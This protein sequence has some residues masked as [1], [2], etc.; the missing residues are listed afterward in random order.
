[1][2]RLRRFFAAPTPFVGSVVPISAVVSGGRSGRQRRKVDAAL[3]GG[4]NGFRTA[5]R[6]SCDAIGS[7]GVLARDSF[8]GRVT[9]R[10]GVAA[11]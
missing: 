10:S 3:T 11:S 1:M 7:C 5:T 4:Q 9:C 8:V 2:V 6:V